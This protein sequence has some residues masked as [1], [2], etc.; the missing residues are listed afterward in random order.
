VTAAAAKPAP[1]R[2]TFY[3]IRVTIL[4]LILGGVLLYAWFDVHRRH[5][6]NEW[7]RPLLIAYVVVCEGPI[8]L[9][10]LKALEDRVPALQQRLTEEMK[11]YKP[12]GPSPPFSVA[13]LGPVTGAA[14]PP[15][16]PTDTG[17]VATALYQYRL[18]RWTSKVDDIDNLDTK[19]FDSRIYLVARPPE[20]ARRKEIEGA[21][22]LGGT[23]GVVRVELDPSMADF[24]LFVASHEMF[25]TLGA[26]DKYA[27]DGSILVP[28]GL[29]EPN[30]QPLYPQRYAE[31]MARHRPI[32]PTQTKPPASIEELAVGTKTATEI[33]WLH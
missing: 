14:P 25:H 13:I 32:S 10:S 1:K 2:G 9:A 12:D 19:A 28:D 11:R 4:L 31:L 16:P 24:T 5:A 17:I 27:P 22:E 20:S 6:R 3:R 29:A 30:L 23:V 33:G 8:D 18:D 21:S 15:E 7:K 26:T